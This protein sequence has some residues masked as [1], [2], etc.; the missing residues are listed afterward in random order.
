[1]NRTSPK[2][3][4]SKRTGFHLRVYDW[5]AGRHVRWLWREAARG[6]AYSAGVSL[7]NSAIVGLHHW[8]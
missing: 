5:I 2:D 1:M 7:I 6:A 4:P 8:L 3:G